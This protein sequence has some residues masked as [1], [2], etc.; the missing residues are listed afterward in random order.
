MEDPLRHVPRKPCGENDIGFLRVF[1]AAELRAWHGEE[2]L[3]KVFWGYG[4]LVSVVL[5]VFYLLAMDEKRVVMQQMLLVALAAYT[6]WIL[7][8]IWRC[9]KGSPWSTLARGLTIAWAANSML[10]LFFLQFDLF[11]AFMER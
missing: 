1:F 5:A 2:A 8:A 6:A 9:A 4:V 10:V 7:V 11:A 3:W